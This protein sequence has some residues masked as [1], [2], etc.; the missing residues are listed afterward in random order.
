MATITIVPRTAIAV[1]NEK[2]IIVGPFVI[3]EDGGSAADCISAA[4]AVIG[5]S[6]VPLTAWKMLHQPHKRTE[7]GWFERQ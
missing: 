1:G 6:L 4:F 5:I 2:V 3:D 7:G